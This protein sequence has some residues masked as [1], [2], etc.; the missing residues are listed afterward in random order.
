MA[1]EIFASA[2]NASSAPDNLVTS[3]LDNLVTSWKASDTIAVVA[4]IVSAIIS[5]ATI[6]VNAWFTSRTRRSE[7]LKV[8]RELMN[9]ILESEKPVAA[10]LDK[11]LTSPPKDE[12]IRKLGTAQWID[13]VGVILIG[14]QNFK[15]EV[16][17]GQINNE[18][19]IK[20]YKK[21]LFGVLIYTKGLHEIFSDL[22][23]LL[24]KDREQ[25]DGWI[26]DLMAWCREGN[27]ESIP[28][29]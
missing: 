7:Q 3:A 24:T 4:L 5:V 6:S 18:S 13:N 28:G 17:R 10:L 27:E 29:T 21:Q 25:I 15:H 22:N 9:R 11:Y 2:I 23:G 16:E 26:T 1:F 19:D 12:K 8:A 14:V 20:L